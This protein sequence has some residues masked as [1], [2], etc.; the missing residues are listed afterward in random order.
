VI[1]G[2]LDLYEASFEIKWLQ[3]AV[4]LQQTQDKL[5]FEPEQNTYFNTAEGQADIIVRMRSS[6]DGAT[7]SENSISALN[8][9]RLASLTGRTELADQAKRVVLSFQD[10][11]ESHPQSMSQLLLATDFLLNK[12]K[13]IIIA[14]KKEDPALSSFLQSIHQQFLPRKVLMFA[15]GAEGQKFLAQENPFITDIKPIDQKPTAFV[16]EDFVCKLPTNDLDT[17]QEQL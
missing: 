7:P 2:L 5:F 1:N 8:L 6:Y 10:T 9:A 13:Q 3:W 15:D 16:C 14:S 11:L 4:E 12:P 17:F